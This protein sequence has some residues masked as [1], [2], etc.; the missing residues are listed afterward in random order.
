MEMNI[1]PDV[2]KHLLMHFQDVKEAYYSKCVLLVE[3][4]TEYGCIR[5]FTKTLNIP[6]DDYGI[7]FVNVRGEGSIPKLQQLFNHFAIPSIVIFDSDVKVGRTAAENE[8]FTKETCFEM[9]IVDKL[10][11]MGKFDTI[12]AIALELDNNAN[13]H[14]LDVDFV[15]KPFKKIGYDLTT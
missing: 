13:V 4:E 5:G 2:E 10:I 1:K 15:K 14:I 8:F 6:L 11:E 9:D 3:G 7:C 12:K